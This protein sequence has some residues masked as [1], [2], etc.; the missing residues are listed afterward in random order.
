MA[1]QLP[2]DR[3]VPAVVID[4]FDNPALC[5]RVLRQIDGIC[6]RLNP[7]GTYYFYPAFEFAANI[8]VS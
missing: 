5:L 2:D 8:V 6:K 4:V 7:V 3:G 1:K